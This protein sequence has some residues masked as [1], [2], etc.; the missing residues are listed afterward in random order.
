MLFS[1]VGPRHGRILT[2]YFDEQ[3]LVVKKTPLHYFPASPDSVA[4][5]EFLRYQAG[6]INLSLDTTRFPDPVKGAPVSV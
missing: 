2:A 5:R 4:M 1:F 6:G 3:N